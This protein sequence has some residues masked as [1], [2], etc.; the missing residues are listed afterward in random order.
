MRDYVYKIDERV[1]VTQTNDCHCGL[2]GVIREF[3]V[4]SARGRP[5]RY[6]RVQLDTLSTEL[7]YWLD[8]IEPVDTRRNFL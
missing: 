6:A 4:S 8:E 2:E 5:H 7:T 3:G 1:R